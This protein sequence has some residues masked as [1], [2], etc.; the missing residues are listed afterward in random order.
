MKLI[1]SLPIVSIILL[2]S[3]SACS[4]RA[5]LS[6]PTIDLAYTLTEIEEPPR[7]AGDTKKS[8]TKIAISDFTA[9]KIKAAHRGKTMVKLVAVYCDIADEDCDKFEKF[10][11][12]CVGKDLVAKVGSTVIFT[13]TKVRE[14]LTSILITRSHVGLSEIEADELHKLLVDVWHD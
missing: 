3:A 10:M 12:K 8:E 1:E 11:R 4:N 2:V 5:A 14:I 6:L 7:P 9:F 13:E